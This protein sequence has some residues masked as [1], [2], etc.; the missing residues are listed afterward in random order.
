MTQPVYAV[1]SQQPIWI[2]NAIG[3]TSTSGAL[4]FTLAA[5][6]FPTAIVAVHAQVVRDTAAPASAAFALVRT[7]TT[8]SVVV[9]VF[10][11]KT[12]SIALGG[13]VEGLEA[14]TSATVVSITVFGY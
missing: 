9:Q 12:T 13:T 1:I 7:Y 10:E 8:T 14:T 6:L 5:G 11:S 4:T 2:H 3:T